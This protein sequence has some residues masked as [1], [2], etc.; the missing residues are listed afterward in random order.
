MTMP[1]PQFT[2]LDWGVVVLYLVLVMAVGLWM[3]RGQNSKRDYFL[4]GRNMPW[5]VVGLSIIATETSALTLIGVPAMALGALTYVNGTFV[6]GTGSMYFLMIVVGHLIGR[7]IIAVWIVPY[8]FRG[9]VYTTYQL[10]TRAFGPSTRFVAA[11]LSFL[12]MTLGAGV[13]I[14]V[15]AI[16]IMMVMRTY[17]ATAWFGIDHAIV[18]LIVFALFY[19]AIGGIKAVVWTDMVQFFIFFGAGLYSVLYIPSLL[20]GELAAPSGAT[21]WGAIREVSGGTLRWFNSGFTEGDPVSVLPRTDLSEAPWVVRQISNILAGPFNLLMGL[22]AMPI[23]IVFALGFD[24]MNVQRVLGCRDVREGRKAVLLSAALIA[25]QFLMFLLVGVAL[26]SFYT[27]GGC[28]FALPPWDP[29]LVDPSTGVGI[30][31]ADYVFPAFIIEHM[32]PVMRGFLVA[33][34]LAAAM[35]SVSSALGAMGSMVAM[36]FWKPLAGATTDAQ[37]MTVSRGAVILS[38][39]LLAA[40]AYWCKHTKSV[41]DL[42]FT[43]AGF[44]SGAVLG[45][46]LYALWYKRGSFVPAAAGMGA[47]VAVMTLLNYLSLPQ[48]SDPPML[49]INWPWHVPIGTI[50]CLA[51]MLALRPFFPAD[52]TRNV[53]HAE[54]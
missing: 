32:P 33:A 6:L 4:G 12:G 43:L 46:F 53:E 1:S 17:E 11:L 10:L 16:P 28:E 30:P 25:P 44:T 51:V 42:A 35:S 52:P 21:G 8:Y 29:A 2:L 20:H 39:I 37:E 45:A 31:K 50:A 14:L 41:F 24:Q 38:G 54:E 40:V 48:G 19:T 9:E 23:G 5:W 36:D 34:I 22:V 26:H 15:T 3:A 13:R 49:R 18:L 7:V 27:L 47:S